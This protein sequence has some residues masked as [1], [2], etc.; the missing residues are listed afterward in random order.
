MVTAEGGQISVPLPVVLIDWK[1]SI[2]ISFN[3]KDIA[4]W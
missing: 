4:A 3:K 2:E 1:V